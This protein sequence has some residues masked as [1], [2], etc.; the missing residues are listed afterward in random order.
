MKISFFESVVIGM[1]FTFGVAVA[2]FFLSIVGFVIMLILS[3]FGI[4]LAGG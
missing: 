2:S 4:A 3:L 1:G